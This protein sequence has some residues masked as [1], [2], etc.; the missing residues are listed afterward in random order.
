MKPEA[1][2]PALNRIVPVLALGLLLQLPQGCEIKPVA[3][4]KLRQ[5]QDP[6]PGPGPQ[7]DGKIL[8]AARIYATLGL[9][10]A[11]A[12]WIA[13]HCDLLISDG[14]SDPWASEMKQAN[15]DLRLFRYVTACLV[16]E[17]GIFRSRVPLGNLLQQH[18]NWFWRTAEGSYVHPQADSLGY[19][20]D[21]GAT[22]D[23]W[24]HYW[25]AEVT[26][27]TQGLPYEGVKGDLA[28]TDLSCVYNTYPDI[29]NRYPTE[30]EFHAVQEACL[31]SFHD[32]LN[33]E[34]KL[35]ILN[36]VTFTSCTDRDYLTSVRIHS[37]DGFIHQGYSMKAK[38][39]PEDPFVRAEAM[40]AQMEA[41]DICVSLQKTIILAAQPREN[42]EEILYCIGCYLLVREDPY[43][44]LNIDWN[45][46]YRRM[47]F[48]FDQ[49]GDL[50]ETDYGQP[51]GPRYQQDGLWL[52]P[53]SEGTAVVDLEAHTFEFRWNGT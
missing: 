47:Q 23:G 35:L 4:P 34:G 30:A 43:V 32:L 12:H 19:L 45:A 14:S 40:E 27:I 6:E 33:A 49:F 51:Q 38:N 37:E 2:S 10:L 52:R 9:T 5:Q 24:S 48:L 22:F 44:Y 21:P 7:A 3:G 25:A 18:D 28:F 42:R 11:D 26:S 13:S 15:P 1:H 29:D 53:Y 17:P 36:N 8:Y 31:S 16:K 50:F 46:D 41:L 20:I 39:H